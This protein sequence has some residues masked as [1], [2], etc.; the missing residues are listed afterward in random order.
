MIGSRTRI[1][2]R[3]PRVC[4]IMAIFRLGFLG[5]W[6]R[7]GVAFSAFAG[8]RFSVNYPLFRWGIS[9]P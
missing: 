2:A 6:R 1:K 7:H 8:H 3:L 9:A 5:P 4:F